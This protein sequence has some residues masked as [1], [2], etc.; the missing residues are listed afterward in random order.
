[1]TIPTSN[2]ASGMCSTVP[3]VANAAGNAVKVSTTASTSHT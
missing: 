3:S 1:M 2:N